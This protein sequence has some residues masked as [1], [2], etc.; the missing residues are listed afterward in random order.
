[1]KLE[2]QTSKTVIKLITSFEFIFLLLGVS[3]PL[4]TIDE[5]WF[6]TSE[7]SV[8]S[9]TYSLFSNREYTLATIIVTFGF[10]IPI[11]KIF[12]KILA[13]RFLTTFPLHKL[14]MLDVFLLSFLVFGGKL[15]YFYQVN[16]QIGFYLMLSSIFLSYLSLIISWNA[17]SKQIK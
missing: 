7:F 14:S 12:Q 16:L 2:A 8:L 17:S 15:S 10:I 1:M 6:F 4:A 11:I 13:H 5:F 9:L 3:L